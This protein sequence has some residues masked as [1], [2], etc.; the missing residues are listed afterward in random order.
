[1]HF[2]VYIMADPIC[3]PQCIQL[4]QKR[5]LQDY[6]VSH[7]TKFFHF[8]SIGIALLLFLKYHHNNKKFLEAVFFPH[9]SYNFQIYFLSKFNVLI[10]EIQLKVTQY[11]AT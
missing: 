10:L 2:S 1:M 4:T 5:Q 11:Y 8:D 9:V 6:S 3:A 7:H